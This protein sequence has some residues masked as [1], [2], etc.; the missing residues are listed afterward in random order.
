MLTKKLMGAGGAGGAAAAGAWTF[1]NQGADYSDGGQSVTV[2]GWGLIEHDLLLYSYAGSDVATSPPFTPTQ[3]GFSVWEGD[4]GSRAV[5]A[6]YF[7][8]ATP[9]TTITLNNGG[10]NGVLL[11]Q[12]WR[13]TTGTALAYP[14]Y[15]GTGGFSGMPDPPNLTNIYTDVL[16]VA[17]G[18]VDNDPVTDVT[19][20]SGYSNLLDEYD[21]EKEECT[22]M[23]ASKVQATTST[24]NPA[25]FGGSGSGNWG[26]ST[27]IFRVA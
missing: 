8:P 19:A 14:G 20:P 16:V 5:Q 23:L 18:G 17:F 7:V 25:A 15:S 26:A 13:H 12:A 21:S 6:W 22:A 4:F 24:E 27:V 3:S 11:V 9:P 1:V 2:S 10:G